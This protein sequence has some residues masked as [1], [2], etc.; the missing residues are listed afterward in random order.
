MAA[1]ERV[2]LTSVARA[3]LDRLSGGQL[4]RVLIARALASEPRMLLLDEPTASV[5]TRIGRSVYELLALLSESMTIVL[6]SHDIGVISRYVKTI[7]CLN[8]S[9]MSR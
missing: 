2:E 1:I 5:D 3:Q 6:V 4:Q 7:A 9:G 8:F